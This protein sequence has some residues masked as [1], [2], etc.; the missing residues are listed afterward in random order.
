MRSRE[1]EVT[2]P[3]ACPCSCIWAEAGLLNNKV[4][5]AEVEALS[6]CACPRKSELCSVGL[7]AQQRKACALYSGSG[8]LGRAGLQL[9]TQKL[10]AAFA[11]GRMVWCVPVFLYS[12][13]AG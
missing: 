1:K 5:R 7:Q 12:G 9:S 8:A 13:S 11:S 4:P 3:F 10:A 2:S 6:A